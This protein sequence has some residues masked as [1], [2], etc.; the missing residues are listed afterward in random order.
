[1]VTILY[2]DQK[3]LFRKRSC[4]ASKLEPLK[5][6]KTGAAFKWIIHIG[7]ENFNL[8]IDESREQVEVKLFS[9]YQRNYVHV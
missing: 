9:C 5:L 2:A 3:Y 7:K 8:S 4:R 6:I 1:M